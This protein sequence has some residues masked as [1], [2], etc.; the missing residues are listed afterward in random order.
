MIDSV[1]QSI[2]FVYRD[3]VW[4]RISNVAIKDILLFYFSISARTRCKIALIQLFSHC[5]E[6]RAPAAYVIVEVYKYLF[7]DIYIYIYTEIIY[8]IFYSLYILFFLEDK[9]SFPPEGYK[10]PET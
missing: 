10:K 6:M 9:F 5:S 8:Y 7:I 4:Q 1:E 2:K 3:R